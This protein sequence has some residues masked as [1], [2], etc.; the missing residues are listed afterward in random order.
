LELCLTTHS[1]RKPWG[2]EVV[3]NLDMVG[4]AP[5]DYWITPT[6]GG[7]STLDSVIVLVQGV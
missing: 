7:E 6:V 3:T 4:W 5:G 1:S 2:H